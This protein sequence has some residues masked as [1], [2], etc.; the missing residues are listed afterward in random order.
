[1]SGRTL[2]P[3]SWMSA[4]G[5][6]GRISLLKTLELFEKSECCNQ[7]KN[8]KVSEKRISLMI[9]QVHEN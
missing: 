7:F 4:R 6:L 8:T 1:M 3:F 9:I 5:L 2:V